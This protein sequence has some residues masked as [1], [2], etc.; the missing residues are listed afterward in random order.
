ME[1]ILNDVEV[2]VLGCLLEKKMATP[3]YYP[4]S[5]NAI[6]NACNQLSNRNPVV[7]YDDGIVESA[8]DELNEKGLIWRS[9]AGRVTKHGERLVEICALAES[10]SAVLCILMLR[11][12]QTAGEIRART[13]RLY[14]FPE[15]AELMNILA[16]LEDT[17]YVTMLARQPGQKESRYAHLLCGI[18]Q[19]IDAESPSMSQGPVTPLP[20][21]TER[22]VEIEKEI[23][24]LRQELDELKQAFTEFKSQFE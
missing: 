3:E 8:L 7:S 12:P 18:P 23:G 15:P 17:G 5:V 24:A 20:T 22:F 11:G 4:L 10:E 6:T 19:A 9:S 2:R 13:E 21:K 16:G 14:E 1:I